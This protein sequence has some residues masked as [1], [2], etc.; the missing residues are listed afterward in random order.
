MI[1]E[2]IWDSTLLGKKIGLLEISSVKPVSLNA[3]LRKA[4]NQ[5]FAYVI[6]KMRDQ[7]T[8][9]TRLLESRGF[10][11]SD[12]GITWHADAEHLMKNIR[13]ESSLSSMI[14]TA[15]EHDIPMLGKMSRSLFTESR[16]YHDPFFSKKD[17][18]MLYRVWTENSVRGKAADIVFFIPNGGFITCRKKGRCAGEIVLI[19]LRPSFRRR[20][21]G[22]ALV[23]K[24]LHWFNN[25][26]IREITVR[27]QAKNI[28]AMN[29]Y[30]K[31]GFTIQGI[32]LVYAKIV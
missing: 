5:G 4:S 22:T 30:L 32:D 28:S 21:Y 12:I 11:L 25:N 20:G 2:L 14:C 1:Q 29:F 18:D 9:L 16:F 31:S 3:A 15:Q 13:G 6:C 24:A 26:R 7:D 17:A 8:R 23:Q 27:T 19:G 10:Y